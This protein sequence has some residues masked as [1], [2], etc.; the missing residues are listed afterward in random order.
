MRFLVTWKTPNQGSDPSY[1][2]AVIKYFEDG[3]PMDKFE[4]FEVLERVIDPHQG[5]GTCI[6]EADNLK[7][8]YQHTGP[9]I[10]SFQCKVEVTPVLS[11]EDYLKAAKDLLS[12]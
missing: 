7:K 3:K 9:W 12:Q 5:G 2:R 10:Q 1:Q 6:V 8:I 4:G 11:D